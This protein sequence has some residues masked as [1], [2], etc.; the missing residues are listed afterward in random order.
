MPCFIHRVEPSSGIEFGRVY[1]RDAHTIFFCAR[2]SDE[3]P[4]FACADAGDYLCD[5]PV[6][7]DKTCNRALCEQHRHSVAPELDYCD[8]HYSEWCEFKATGAP[9][10]H[11]EHVIPC[12]SERD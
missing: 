6:G 12:R 8:L 11:F 4:C 3:S 1:Q 5:Y 10:K 9:L 7:K 2:N